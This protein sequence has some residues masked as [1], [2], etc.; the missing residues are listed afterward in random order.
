MRTSNSIKNTI[1]ALLVSFCS[2]FLGIISQSLFLKI[3]NIEYLGINGLFSNII[4]ML[5]I[6]ELGIGNAIIVNLYKPVYEQNIE[7]IKALMR[8]YKRAYNIVALI[9]LAIGLSL[10]PFLKYIVGDVSI[11]IN[12]TAI[13]LL[14]VFSTVS[15]YLLIYKRTI[16]IAHQK[17]YILN[18]IEI[19]YL[20]IYNILQII[21]LYI[22]ENYYLY[23]AIKII[24]QLIENII[25]SIYANR[26]YKYLKEKECNKLDKQTEK[27]IFTKMKSLFFHK[28][29]T[30]IVK[31]TDNII[32]STFLGVSTVGLYSNYHTIINSVSS[33]FSRMMTST[34][35][36][37]GNLLVEK[38]NEKTYKTFKKIRFLNF[39][40]A[41][42]SSSCLLN[43]MQNFISVW[44]G[45]K[46][47]LDNYVL[48]ILVLNYFFN[49]M[50]YCY[51][52]FKDAAGIWQEDKWI[53]LIES[54]MNIIISI[55]LVKFLGLSGVFL[56]TFISSLVMWCYS[57]PK[58]VHK[59]LFK[60]NYNEYIKDNIK[61]FFIFTL[62]ISLSYFIS[63]LVKTEKLLINLL[64]TILV[65]TIIPNILIML[66][67]Y[68]TEEF[69]YFIKLTKNILK[70]IITPK[71]TISIFK[72]KKDLY[73]NFDKENY[74]MIIVT[75]ITGAGKSFTTA[76]LSEEYKIPIFCFDYLYEYKQ[77]REVTKF[78]KEILNLFYSKYPQ[79]KNTPKIAKKQ[80]KKNIEVQ[81]IN[82]NFFDFILEYLKKNKLRIVFDGASFC[83]CVNYDKF[84]NQRIVIK[85]T[86]FV[87]TIYRRTLRCIKRTKGTKHRC[88]KF[89][90]DVKYTILHLREWYIT[91][92]KF[93]KK[94]ETNIEK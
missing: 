62:V 38:N 68:N 21:I 74:T 55:I 85:R 15:S 23:L 44:I 63:L 45:K 37:V 1:T 78:E 72:S 42:F 61:Y 86:S 50:K 40:I 49:L 10:T 94:I 24:C 17:N 73:I 53:P 87:K 9:V 7:K 25:V 4:T 48:Y 14:F 88:I 91:I 93:L 70:K 65:S 80:K 41:T 18:V 22:T 32:I 13:Y 90:K 20:I 67:F 57:Y 60:K 11:N 35:A 69:K 30:F 16:L 51:S 89:A 12:L 66:I 71:I 92:N 36:S 54:I 29:A 82:D 64:F 77:D 39:W 28:I 3:L 27:N 6:A 84:K 79:Y 8:F 5:G 26:K 43:I 81:E 83:N 34:T 2:A 76:K 31:G 75:G 59:K 33:L 52:I 56:G 19:F 47:L 46:Y 58:F